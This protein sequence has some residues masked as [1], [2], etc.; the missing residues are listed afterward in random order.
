[1][2]YYKVYEYGMWRVHAFELDSSADAFI[3]KDAILISEEEAK[4]LSQLPLSVEL[5][6]ALDEGAAALGGRGLSRYPS[7]E[8]K[9]AIGHICVNSAHIEVTL[10]TVI[11]Q[12]AGIP[13]EV[14]MALTGGKLAIRELLATL[15]TLLDVRYPQLAPTAKEIINRIE[16]LNDTRGRYVHGL[17][18]P[19]SNGKA[20]VSKHF[21][22][23]IHAK[24]QGTEVSIDELYAIAEGYMHAESALLEKILTPLI[25]NVSPGATDHSR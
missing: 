13:A 12:V 15:T 17:W 1:M 4:Q 2:R 7:K 3:P 22:T 10:R 23:R 11:W 9:E 18:H 19:G 25:S 24:G 16:N 8:F 20:I 14:G 21:L 5:Q 6:Q